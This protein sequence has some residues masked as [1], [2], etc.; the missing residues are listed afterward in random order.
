MLQREYGR[1]ASIE[2]A[3]EIESRRIDF[4]IPG[5]LVHDDERHPTSPVELG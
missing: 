4:G 2:R 1:A 5:C 3:H